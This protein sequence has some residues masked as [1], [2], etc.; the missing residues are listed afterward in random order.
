[1]IEIYNC[2]N[3][4]E[5]K[6]DIKKNC[7]NIKYAINGTWKTTIAKAI[8]LYFSDKNNGT[9]M[10]IWLKPFKSL[11]N[12][13]IIPSINW[14]DDFNSIEIFNEDYVNNITFV[15][16]WEL[17]KWSFEVFIKDSEYD[18]RMANIDNLLKEIIETFKEDQNLNS[19]IDELK[20][21]SSKTR[22]KSD[23]TLHA[24]CEFKKA[25]DFWNLVDNIPE[26][27]VW[28]SEYIKNDN[29]V[30]WLARLLKGKSYVNSNDKCPCCISWITPEKKKTF[31]KLTA[32]YDKSKIEY[33]NNIIKNF[34]SLKEYFNE[35]TWDNICNILHKWTKLTEIEQSYILWVKK[36]SDILLSN[37]EAIKNIDFYT[38]KQSSDIQTEI[39]DLI[40]K[41]QLH[42]HFKSDIFIKRI[43]PINEKLNNVL[44]QIW[45][46]QGAINNHKLQIKSTI[47]SYKRDINEFL[48][49]GWY[50]YE[51]D[52]IEIEK[53]YSL[54]LKHI[55]KNWPL[56]NAKNA[57]SFGE[58]NALALI[59]FMFDVLSKKTDLI[60]LDDPISSFDKNK[61]FA[62]INRLFGQK[63][64]KKSLRWK[65]VVMLTHDFE[66]IIDI[67]YNNL[68]KSLQKEEC[69]VKFL[70]NRNNELVEKEIKKEDISSC[71]EIAKINIG[72]VENMINKLIYYRR[73]LEV[74]WL[75][76]WNAYQLLSNLFKKREKPIKKQ[77]NTEVDMTE[78]EIEEASSF[79]KKD[80]ADFEYEVCYK[81]VINIE[82]MIHYYQHSSNNYEKLQ[83]YRIINEDNH[84]DSVIRKFINETFHI[85][86]DYLF[87]LNP[88]QFEIVPQY[89]IDRCDED[90]SSI[91][92]TKDGQEN[93]TL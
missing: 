36:E 13:K 12:E 78:E 89:I 93:W 82:K 11:D 18:K 53:G 2:Q 56:Q 57:L 7:L 37:L 90:L 16:N 41:H 64:D 9:N 79:I 75:K 26:E 8:K 86:N 1:M 35:I 72:T 46:L 17:L 38:L 24:S 44:G 5:W 32:T 21:L 49:S 77:W 3:I 69:T 22:Q 50:N 6:I 42:G 63:I 59:L 55:D 10:L 85:E 83:I 81:E 25:L 87:Q 4:D 34:E 29:R 31:E 76:W 27:L 19:L 15:Q 65:T 80:I 61:K 84:D 91:I 33:L 54:V 62:I 14:L 20:V 23:W 67:V 45:Q 70:D 47:D 92:K 51:I 74:E 30:E 66:P 40:I 52:S 73:L 28:Y 43:N 39:G 60:V 58:R 88:R 48:I 71:I 68:P